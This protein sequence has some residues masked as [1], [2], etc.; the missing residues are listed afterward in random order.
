VGE[1]VSGQ[2]VEVGGLRSAAVAMVVLLLAPLLVV[3]PQPVAADEEPVFGE[4]GEDVVLAFSGLTDPAVGT[5]ALIEDGGLT[6][7]EAAVWFR[8]AAAIAGA[9]VEVSE[10]TLTQ[11]T[12]Q[13]DDVS[14][15]TLFA[16]SIAFAVESGIS[17]GAADGTFLPDSP[18]T[19]AQYAAFLVRSLDVANV[20][21]PVPEGAPLFDD[22]VV[23]STFYE[24]IQVLATAEIFAAGG[25]FR[26]NDVMSRLQAYVWS[27]GVQEFVD[28]GHDPGPLPGGVPAVRTAEIDNGSVQFA[29]QQNEPG[30]RT[31]ALIVDEQVIEQRTVNWTEP[32]PE[33]DPTPPPSPPAPTPAPDLEPDPEL[34]APAPPARTPAPEE[35]VE[36]VEPEVPAGT[37][38]ERERGTAGA[39]V[40]GVE[41]ETS[42]SVPEVTPSDPD[43]PPSEEEVEQRRT[44]TR[45]FVDQVL[46]D[47]PADERGVSV[48]DTDDGAAIVGL[49][50]DRDDATQ[51]RPVP[52]TAVAAVSAG[53]VRLLAAVT[54]RRGNP[55]DRA[56]DGA[57]RG[58]PGGDAAVRMF[59]LPAEADGQMQVR[60]TARVLASVT[61]DG[62][63][64]LA[65]QV[66]VPSDLPPGD[67]TL[68][69]TVGG[70][71]TSIGIT[72]EADFPDVAAESTHVDAIEALAEDGVFQGQPDG[73]FGP[74]QGLLRAQMATVLTRLLDL[75]VDPDA[76]APFDDVAEDATHGPAIAAIT[77]SGLTDGCAQQRFCP[78][79]V[80]T[81][82]QLAAFLARA[83]DLPEA[84]DDPFTDIATVTLAPEIRAAAA[85]GIIDGFGDGTFRPGQAV[86]RAQAASMLFNAREVAE[87]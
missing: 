55:R 46:A 65:S 41:V 61:T 48:E 79:T 3:L 10:A 76:V 86:S 85:A 45:Q 57:L 19:R 27:V 60:S 7:G 69:V 5:A 73:T 17:I 20:D 42:V 83:Y 70:T 4:V 35:Q 66:E 51:S 23:G 52:P 49:L 50:A 59:G 21:L 74:A 75:E 56:A 8:R 30:E 6:R 71:T 25:N 14:P 11:A 63:G 34:E 67:H 26:P 29:V 37:T 62:A 22:V 33:P 44:V 40:D 36:A 53:D 87:E 54:D 77:A 12:D 38:V 78:T 84:D 39:V 47:V 9:N 80:V 15:D 28:S 68:V 32:D 58:A 24:V 72:V 31:Y 1:R 81:R 13:F 18:L 16:E 82:G 64:R 2:M 43:V